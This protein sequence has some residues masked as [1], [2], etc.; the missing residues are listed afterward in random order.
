[1]EIFQN[2]RLELDFWNRNFK[3]ASFYFF[4]AGRSYG[5]FSNAQP[6]RRKME[7]Y[8]VF[9]NKMRCCGK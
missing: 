5:M 3:L 1:V 9:R 6:Y 2:R 7:F 4:L 8:G